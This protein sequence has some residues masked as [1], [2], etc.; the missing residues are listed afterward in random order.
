MIRTEKKD[1]AWRTLWHKP[2]CHWLM[3]TRSGRLALKDNSGERPEST[4]DGILWLDVEKLSKHIITVDERDREATPFKGQLYGEHELVRL[5]LCI[6]LI[7]GR[8][9]DHCG[10]STH[11]HPELVALAMARL[12]GVKSI[13]VIV[14]LTTVIGALVVHAPAYAPS[15]WMPGKSDREDTEDFDDTH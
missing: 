11:T 3:E 15:A 1:L 10:S 8:K 2:D 7:S 4:D 5:S 13:H 12:F 9:G 6:P 14:D